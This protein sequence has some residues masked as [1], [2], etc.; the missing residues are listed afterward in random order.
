[1]EQPPSLIDRLSAASD[2]WARANDSHIARLGRLVVNDTS[3]F[4][5]LPDRVKGPSTDTLEKFAR[6]LADPAN[7][8]E[9]RVAAEAVAFA[10]VVGVSAPD[11]AAS[12]G[13]SGEVS[14]VGRAVA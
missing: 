9:G 2:A 4:A 8:P 7:W 14:G 13:L 1:M 6:F 10:H 11:G 12:A 5:G 3:F